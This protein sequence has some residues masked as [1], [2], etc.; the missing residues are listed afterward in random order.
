[1]LCRD[2][3]VT[4]WLRC[5]IFAALTTLLFESNAHAQL[6][7]AVPS[8]TPTQAPAPGTGLSRWFNPKTA[9]FI[10]VPEIAVDPDSGTTLGVLPTWI[11][12]DENH[13]ITKIVAPD[14]LHNPYFGFGAHARIY[15]YP[16]EDEQWSVVGGIKQ[17]VEREFDAEFQHGRAR[18]KRWSF[19]GSLIYDRNGTPR[20][21]GFGNRSLLVSETNYTGQQEVGQAQIGFNISKIWQVLYTARM[22]VVDVLPGTLKGI[23][24]VSMGWAP[25]KSC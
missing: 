11:G 13:N 17:R 5:L 25:T 22:R 8:E 10:P 16:S 9:P 12:T 21:Y 4:C 6:P 23:P 19:T 1:M 18:K 7:A 20:F 2:R 3:A 14:L 24:S 15:A